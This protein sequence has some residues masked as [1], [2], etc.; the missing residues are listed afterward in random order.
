M[1]VLTGAGISTASGIPDYRGPT[2]A[3]RARLP[4]TYQVFTRRPGRPAALLGA[5]P[6]RLAELR[7]AEPNTA[8]RCVGDLQRALAC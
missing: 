4:M 1:L 6:A 2:G 8:H 3:L 5:Q 7:R